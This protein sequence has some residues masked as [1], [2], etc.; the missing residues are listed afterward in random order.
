MTEAA[1]KK[2]GNRAAL[3]LALGRPVKGPARGKMGSEPDSDDA[4]D[5][6][7]EPS[8]A[9]RKSTAAAD[10][11]AAFKSDDAGALEDA[12][13]RFVQACSSEGYE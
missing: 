10:A 4:G 11:L 13:S 6:G 7:A 9:E 12:L 8:M 2:P 3:L 5:E 1:E